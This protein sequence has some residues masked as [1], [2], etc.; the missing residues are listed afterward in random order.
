MNNGDPIK[1]DSTQDKTYSTAN[2]VGGS[3]GVN[4]PPGAADVTINQADQSSHKKGE[5]DK[6]TQPSQQDILDRIR[7]GELWMIVFTAVVALTTVAQFIQSGCNNRSTSKQVEKIIGAAN[8]QACAANKIA[9]AAD[10]F[11]TSAA[12]I[13]TGIGTAVDKLDLQAD[14]LQASVKEAHAL[15]KTTRES[16]KLARDNFIKDER[17]YV[18]INPEEAKV[19]V[20]E[21]VTW[22]VKY[23]NYGRSPA[24]KLRSCSQIVIMD[25]PFPID[26]VISKLPEPSCNSPLHAKII[27]TG[28]LPK[29]P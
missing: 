6:P 15:A 18:W 9:G 27:S 16:L 2:A 1:P 20:G 26:T 13:N 28:I 17:P 14:R 24:I 5:T 19:K 4:P 3:E 12:N 22:N 10:R 23:S 29:G 11:S 7:A 8:T 25:Q 21:Q